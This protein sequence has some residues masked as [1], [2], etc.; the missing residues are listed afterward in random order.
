[1]ATRGRVVELFSSIQGEGLLAGTPQLFLR[2]AGC[3]LACP[4]CDTPDAMDPAGP[5]AFPDARG[6]TRPNPI[7]AP[8][9]A[10]LLTSRLPAPDAWI[11]VTGGEPLEQAPFLAEL[12]PLLAAAGA[13]LHLETA[14]VHPEEAAFILPLCHHL[15]LDWKLP[16]LCG[17]D[18]RPRHRAFLDQVPRQG[19]QAAVKVVLTGDTPFTEI[20]E[21]ARETAARL[22]AATLVLQP[23][24]TTAGP[25]PAALAH[26]LDLLPRLHPLHPNLRLLPQLHKLLALP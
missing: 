4:W 11:A 13:R 12:L 14:A 15:S 19:E 20:V 26:A 3:S 23:L 17:R 24:A 8:D 22:P 16:S 6:G 25:D 2:L 18:W 7:T 21:A 9:L 10:R 5:A 1:M